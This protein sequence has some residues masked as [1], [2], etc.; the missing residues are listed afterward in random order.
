MPDTASLTLNV[1]S[2]D[3]SSEVGFENTAFTALPFE[4]HASI[5]SLE[6]W[7]ALR[8]AVTVTLKVEGQT[9][10]DAGAYIDVPRLNA[11][12]T[13]VQNVDVNC[14]PLSDSTPDRQDDQ[15][16]L[17]DVIKV[18]VYGSWDYGAFAQVTFTPYYSRFWLIRVDS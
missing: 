15:N 12:V 5:Q 1:G 18:D 4:S 17:K 10:G 3:S 14:K 9:L 8:S 11:K 6:L 16:I 7:L 13:P 2:P